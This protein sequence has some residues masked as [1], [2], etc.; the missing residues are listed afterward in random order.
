[1]EWE[2]EKITGKR[3]RKSEQEKRNRTKQDRN[4][5][6]DRKKRKQ[7]NSFFRLFLHGDYFIS[8]LFFAGFYLH[9]YKL[10]VFNFK[11]HATVKKYDQTSKSEKRFSMLKIEK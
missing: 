9:K 6:K 7:T 10:L 4:R 2:K 5:E 3:E 11:I 1:M 8:L